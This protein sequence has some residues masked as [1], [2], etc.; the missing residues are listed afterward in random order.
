VHCNAL[1]RAR[2][3][4]DLRKKAEGLPSG[5]NDT[6]EAALE[7]VMHQH[8]TGTKAPQR[9]EQ[10][11]FLGLR[12][13]AIVSKARRQ[14]SVGELLHA[15]A[16]EPGELSFDKEALLDDSG[17]IIRTTGGLLY[18]REGAVDVCHKTLTDYLCTSGIRSKYFP[19]VDTL[20]E[21]C[22][23]YMNY[24][25]FGEPCDEHAARKKEFPL[26]QYAVRNVGHHVGDA[27]ER[28]PGLLKD[29]LKFLKGPI[30]LGT[31]QVAVSP[32]LQR[33]IALRMKGV[34]DSTPLLHMAVLFG[35][36][37]LLKEIIENHVTKDRGYKQE[38]ALH[39][40]AR[41]RQVEAV[42]WLVDAGAPVNATSYSGKTPLD[43]VMNRPYQMFEIRARETIDLA[44]ILVEA[45]AERL[46]SMESDASPELHVEIDVEVRIQM[47]KMTAE[48]FQ[49]LM[50]TDFREKS[51][52]TAKT[53]ALSIAFND[54]HLDISD[55]EEEIV[56]KLL[57]ANADI[58]SEFMPEATALQLASIYC[59]PGIV[60]ALL[61]KRANPF[62]TRSL[63]YT[64][65]DLARMR[66]K[67]GKQG[68]QWKA[69]HTML[70]E[71]MAEWQ[72][73]ELNEPDEK[74]KVLIPG[75][76]QSEQLEQ[77]ASDTFP[78]RMKR[79]YAEPIATLWALGAENG[80]ELETISRKYK[81]P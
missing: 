17:D 74:K 44:S 60:R 69:I 13:L 46:E 80:Q 23:T 6:F 50:G 49:T 76:K 1:D 79:M 77:K 66:G 37:F 64:A 26:L 19:E 57:E 32:T 16:V 67:Y 8:R 22:L 58:N 10:K 81:S 65:C 68:G 78:D 52:E 7:I 12:I 18:I 33:P 4:K 36:P 54:V 51:K 47:K 3:T 43:V 24:T 21:I 34:R 41:A 42:R 9:H 55:E 31:F 35:M 73:E 27:M 38:T 61:D 39:T 28:N 2:S 70:A 53:I 56:I 15:L 30:P 11:D 63:G 40:A 75:P 48:R 72:Q 29:C 25:D 59:R 5:I 71:K 14:L 62:L 20:A 45:A